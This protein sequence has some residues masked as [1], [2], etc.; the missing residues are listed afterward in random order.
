MSN[1]FRLIFWGLLFILLDIRIELFDLL[2]DIVGY[3]FIMNGTKYL[4]ENEEIFS[5]AQPLAISLIFLSIPSL[6]GYFDLNIGENSTVLWPMVY[7]LVITLV[8]LFMMYYIFEG[9][10]QFATSKGEH[11]WANTARKVWSYYAIIQ[12]FTLVLHSF[13]LNVDSNFMQAILIFSIIITLIIEIVV[14]IFMKRSRGHCENLDF[15]KV[16]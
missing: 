10:Y 14:I 8:H 15:Q 13:M 4:S 12:F 11:D 5:K 16:Q 2:P 6:I 1:G 7:Q 3:I 9:T